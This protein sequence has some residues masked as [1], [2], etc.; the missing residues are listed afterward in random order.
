M[1]L[2][3]GQ[4]HTTK[5][6]TVTLQWRQSFSWPWPSAESCRQ[7]VIKLQNI[8]SLFQLLCS[9]FLYKENI[10]TDMRPT[11]MLDCNKNYW[12]IWQWVAPRRKR[13]EREKKVWSSDAWYYTKW[14]LVLHQVMPGITPSDAWYYT[15]WCLVL[16][17]L[18]PG[19]TPTAIASDKKCL[20]LA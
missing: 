4:W 17:Q 10:W 19:I 16:H 9:Y 20:K 14:C 18:M 1:H 11:N 5:H 8:S 3:K 2:H 7:M 15:N 12:R 6:T 13:K